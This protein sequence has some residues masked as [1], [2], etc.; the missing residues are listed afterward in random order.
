M[1]QF[2]ISRSAAGDRF[3]LRSDSGRILAVSR[4]YA[5]LD[6]CKKGIASLIVNAPVIP[7]LDATVGEYGRNPKF[8]IVV[9]GAGFAFLMK[10]ANGKS[11]LTSPPYATKKACLRAI[12]MLRRGVSDYEILFYTGEGLTPLTMKPPRGAAA[13]PASPKPLLPLAADKPLFAPEPI[14]AE[15]FPDGVEQ[16]QYI[17]DEVPPAAQQQPLP[18]KAELLKET[19]PPS[20]T[21]PPKPKEEP[22]V[23]PRLIRLEKS[24]KA[25]PARGKTRAPQ[26]ASVA[27]DLLSKLFKKYK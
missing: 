26:K 15:S 23:T 20:A 7:V 8:E 16:P 21:V 24:P 19:L 11:V 4:D 25:S 18:P 9:E 17:F 6:A 2:I 27:R 3:S 12:A 1:G 5:T 22:P 14:E 10:S 13:K